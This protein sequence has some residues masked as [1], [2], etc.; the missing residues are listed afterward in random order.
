MKIVITCGPSY[1]PIDGVRRITNFSTGELG[2]LLANRLARDS[3]DVTLFKGEAAT[4]PLA[5]DRANVIRFSTNDDLRE[6]LTTLPG[7]E[8]V[9]AVFHAAALC[10]FK[11]TQI[12]GTSGNAIAPLKIPSAIPKVQLVLEPVPKLIAGLRALFS[13]SKITG[14]KYELVGSCDEAV[15][16]ALQQI[17]DNKT[18]A[19]VVNGAAYGAGF[20]FCDATGPIFHFEGKARLCDFLADEFIG[21]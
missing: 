3:H 2:L 18:D 4:C 15:A 6:K 17:R 1:E 8:N 9:G 7:R 10:D 21:G 19:C 16:R 20:G 13:K 11:V 12:L 5:V 14:W